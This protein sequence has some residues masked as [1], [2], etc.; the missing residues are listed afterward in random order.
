M[1]GSPLAIKVARR[2][3]DD[4][5][6]PRSLVWFAFVVSASSGLVVGCG[7]GNENAAAQADHRSG[8]TGT[9]R[10]GGGDA[11]NESEVPGMTPDDGAAP[12]PD[13]SATD[14]GGGGGDADGPPALAAACGAGAVS[15]PPI[16]G[17]PANQTDSDQMFRS[18]TV[19]PTNPDVVFA[20]SEGNGMFRTVDGGLTWTWL[21]A[22]LRYDGFQAYAETWDMAVAPSNP[23]VVYAAMTDSPGPVSGN[24]PSTRAGVYRSDDRGDTWRQVGCDLPNS[25]ASS[26]YVD[27][28]DADKVL[29]SIEAG[30]PSFTNPPLSYYPGGLFKS[31]DGG[32]HFTRVNLP[33]TG[34]RSP[35]WWIASRGE[36]LWAFSIP[37]REAPG[38]GLGFLVSQNKGAVWT[39]LA[40]PFAGQLVGGWDVSSDGQTI[41]AAVRDSFKMQRSTDGGVSFAEVPGLQHSPQGPITIHPDSTQIVLYA[42][43]QQLFRSVDGLA[44]ATVVLTAPDNIEEIVFAPSN[45]LI[46]YVGTR[47]LGVHKSIDGG[48]TFVEVAA[49]RSTLVD[50]S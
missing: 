37:E 50:P 47:R 44:N 22:G 42:G 36:K 13:G 27:P 4:A 3:A 41:L 2:A 5:R 15:A 34:D 7:G 17:P 8:D 31:T 40:T 48:A 23:M 26:L 20:G 39:P 30:A 11:G 35:F 16:K 10:D 46:V 45:H 18:L 38:T 29:V 43:N 33:G 32:V 1:G 28:Q 21:R 49:L 6:M 14:A 24:F 9:A 19:D 25:K 12:D